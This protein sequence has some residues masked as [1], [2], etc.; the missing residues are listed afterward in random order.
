M[1][2]DKTYRRCSCRIAL[3]GEDG[4]PVITE[5]G[6]PKTRQLGADC[7]KLTQKNHGRWYFSLDF[8]AT[9][10][11]ERDRVK[12]GGFRTQTKAAEEAS[13]TY[14]LHNA[15]ILGDRV[16]VAAFLAAWLAGKKDLARSTKDAYG[17]HIRLYLGPQLGHL[18]ML[19]LEP[20][21]I[22]LLFDAIDDENERR[23]LHRDMVSAMAEEVAALRDAWRSSPAPR[24]PELRQTW[25]ALRAQLAVERKKQKR[26]TNIATQHRI[27]ATLSSA[28][29][30][31]V[32]ELK[33]ER[34]WAA[35]VTL[36]P[37]P[38]PKP[39]VWTAARIARW[40]ETGEKP[41]PVMVWTPLLAGAFL[42]SVMQD[43]L[44]DMWHL[45]MTR[46]PRRGEAC[47]LPWTEADFENNFIGITRQV[48]AISHKVYGET[49]KADSVRTVEMDPVN[50]GMLLA[51]K[52][53]QRQQ[54]EKILAAG[55]EWHESD[56]IYTQ[57]DGK[58]YHPDYLTHRFGLLV[59][60][61]GLPPV[62]LHD[63]RHMTATFG[64]I[65]GIDMKGVSAL[66]GHSCMQITSDTYTS[67]IPQFAQAE[68]AAI[69]SVI[70]REGQPAIVKVEPKPE[71][72]PEHCADVGRTAHPVRHRRLATARRR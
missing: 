46:G 71:P 4:K 44:Y 40:Q 30:D 54:R 57:D 58:P 19:D 47:A 39:L 43:D 15:G 1:F 62:R 2:E 37:A 65:A 20:Q 59:E 23:Q 55:G 17:R 7:P 31:A 12:K 5:S 72:T 8:P 16:T 21:H 22:R 53:R 32:R 13:R 11:K 26:L 67:V 35:L 6:K 49:P 66:L 50:K 52:E 29:E 28:L 25:H 3:L 42:D 60:K 56:L 70:P 9:T 69:V 68:A 51:R 34:N 24:S 27:K 41:G 38:R 33:I 48:V 64:R 36:A 18:D 63:A 61:S 14:R 45:F 10:G